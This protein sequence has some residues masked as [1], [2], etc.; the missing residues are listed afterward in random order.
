MKRQLFVLVFL[1]ALAPLPVLATEMWKELFSEQLAEAEAGNVDARYEVGVM[2]LKGQ[3]VE[4][5]RHKAL[6][7]KPHAETRDK[8]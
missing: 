2:Y 1:S 5:D 6:M 4:Q 8:V 7:T 3:G